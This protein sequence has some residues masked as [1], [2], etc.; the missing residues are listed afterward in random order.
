M[1]SSFPLTGE[2]KL[3]KMSESWGATVLNELRSWGQLPNGTSPDFQYLDAEHTDTGYATATVVIG[4]GT[5]IINV[6]VIIRDWKLCPLDVMEH[7]GTFYP[8]TARRINSIMTFSSPF[9]KIV[10]PNTIKNPGEDLTHTVIPPIQRGGFVKEFSAADPNDLITTR[11]AREI[12]RPEVNDHLVSLGTSAYQQYRKHG[13]YDVI[14]GILKGV[15]PKD[16]QVA[17]TLGDK[18]EIRHPKADFKILWVPKPSEADASRGFGTV[19]GAGGKSFDPALIHLPVREML[20]FYSNANGVDPIAK[21][22]LFIDE[23]AKDGVPISDV[24]WYQAGREGH[25]IGV[26]ELNL[27]ALDRQDSLVVLTAEK[28]GQGHFKKTSANGVIK[29]LSNPASLDKGGIG[30]LSE[31]G[32]LII[33]SKFYGSYLRSSRSDFAGGYCPPP[34]SSSFFDENDFNPEHDRQYL[35]VRRLD[36][37]GLEAVGPLKILSRATM[38]ISAAGEGHIS[39]EYT[40]VVGLSPITVTRSSVVQEAAGGARGGRLSLML[41][42]DFVCVRLN[43]V[44]NSPDTPSNVGYTAKLAHEV[45][46]DWIKGWSIDGGKTVTLDLPTTVKTAYQTVLDQGNTGLKLSR[47]EPKHAE[48]VLAAA[49]VDP[50]HALLF[51]KS[52]QAGPITGYGVHLKAAHPR[53]DPTSDQLAK[54]AQ[55]RRDLVNNIHVELNRLKIAGLELYKFAAEI[56][57]RK[58]VDAVLGLGLSNEDNVDE[59]IEALPRYETVLQELA[60]TLKDS[61]VADSPVQEKI[62]QKAMIALENFVEQVESFIASLRKIRGMN[63]GSSPAS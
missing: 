14:L 56:S 61:R 16:G 63:V 24:D 36:E 11:M 26:S 13:T 59:L 54:E 19:L 37:G 21:S 9:E 55:L 7:N 51:V 34:P 58:T 53:V 6:P 49:G 29:K 33:G 46:Q 39:T 35:F 62:T 44:Y 23:S 12:S 4:L 1:S 2:K 38:P 10:D 15:N 42:A 57:D 40:G 18:M 3:P 28:S 50:K 45:D 47:L 22:N 31:D 41:P 20:E 43:G 17:Q 32:A 25:E 48:F 8:L 52:A 5:N 60:E 30:F 27:N